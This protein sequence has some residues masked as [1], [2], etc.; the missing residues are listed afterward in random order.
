MSIVEDARPGRQP[1]KAYRWRVVDAVEASDLPPV[2][3]H[4]MVTLCG[5]LRDDGMHTGELGGYSPSLSL[6]AGLTGWK[7]TPVK[8]YLG[9]LERLG[10]LIRVQPPVER[11]SVPVRL[12]RAAVQ[13]AREKL[14]STGVEFDIQPALQGT[15][16]IAGGGSG[17]TLR[18]RRPLRRYHSHP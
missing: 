17:K 9:G 6:L 16:S 2:A 3:R 15:V 18:F 11:R 13:T 12:G 14:G 8:K 5:R 10:W 7:P 1:P 4:L